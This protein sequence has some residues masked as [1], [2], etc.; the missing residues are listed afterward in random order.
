MVQDYGSTDFEIE[1]LISNVSNGTSSYSHCDDDNNKNNKASVGQ[2]SMNMIKMCIGTGCLALPYAVNEGGSLW[3]LLGMAI[4]TLWNI[5]STDRLLKC[6]KYM[7]EYNNHNHTMIDTPY[8]DESVVG[9]VED[10]D[11]MKHSK[12]VKETTSTFG[13]VTY[14]A[15]GNLGLQFIDAMMMTLM[16][17]I[18]V[19][20]E[21]KLYLHFQLL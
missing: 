16:F 7:K 3:F 8:V 15:F 2:T 10:Y 18:I 20:Y 17:G 13:Q 11:T 21:G 1:K 5:Y 19:A 12:R 14:F 6:H 4:V 9:G